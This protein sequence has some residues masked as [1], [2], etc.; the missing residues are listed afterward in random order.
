MCRKKLK[1]KKV[2]IKIAIYIFTGPH[3]VDNILIIEKVIHVQVPLNSTPCAETVYQI[4]YILHPIFTSFSF[5][6]NYKTI[7]PAA[8]SNFTSNISTRE[9]HHDYSPIIYQKYTFLILYFG[10]CKFV[11][12][13]SSNILN[14]QG[15]FSF[16][17]PLIDNSFC[18]PDSCICI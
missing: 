7:S 4:S 3:M 10:P 8:T 14:L 6:Y 11:N 16:Q 1:K 9:Q 12:N 2:F 13:Y 15:R 17:S 5:S 18:Y